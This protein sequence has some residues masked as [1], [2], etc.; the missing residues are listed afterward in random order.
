MSTEP[1]DATDVDE[2]A[3][4]DAN[5]VVISTGNECWTGVVSEVNGSSGG[6]WLYCWHNSWPG[7]WGIS[8]IFGWRTW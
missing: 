8:W 6:I 7:C 1:V 5:E 4:D 2:A 3:F